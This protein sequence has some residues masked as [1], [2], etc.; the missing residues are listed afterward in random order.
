MVGLRIIFAENDIVLNE[1]VCE[2]LQSLSIE[3]ICVY[4]GIAAIEAISRLEYLT[5]LLTEVNLGPG[6]DGFDVARY[7]RELYPHLPVVFVS[8]AI[9][10]RHAANGFAE[11]AF[12]A[13]PFHQRQILKAL[14]Q[15]IRLEA[16]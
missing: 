6:P 11:S 9:G 8:G 12:V 5:A 7:A 10:S 16:A 2:F 13:K 1:A 15:V 4:S 3:V 14:G